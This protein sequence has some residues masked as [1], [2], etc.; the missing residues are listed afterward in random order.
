MNTPFCRITAVLVCIGSAAAVPLC[1]ADQ[2]PLKAMDADSDGQVSSEEHADGA[3][4][5]FEKADLDHDDVITA[6][7]LDQARKEL[8]DT[9]RI[10][11][12]ELIMRM[13]TN[14]DGEL[15][16]E[17]DAAGAEAL[18]E[19]ADQDGDGKVDADASIAIP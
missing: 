7:E 2:F 10:S 13:D 17:E 6:S 4:E 19:R 5:N 18:F 16:S 1:M 9:R 12:A 11:S 3:R 15:T 8:G 14:L